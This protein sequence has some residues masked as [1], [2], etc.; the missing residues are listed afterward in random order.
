MKKSILIYIWVCVAAIS[1]SQDKVYLYNGQIYEG[2][3]IHN[4]DSLVMIRV[5]QQTNAPSDLIFY[6]DKVS[7]VK[8]ATDQIGDYV[9]IK[10]VNGRSVK[11][12]IVSETE[13]TI[14]LGEVKG[15]KFGIIEIPKR[16]I[17]Y[18]SSAVESEDINNIK[19]KSV[20]FDVGFLRGASL[21]GV[22]MEIVT[23]PGSTFFL[24]LGYKGFSTGLNGFFGPNHQGFGLKLAYWHQGFGD[25][26]AGSLLSCGLAY[27]MRPG[28]SLD[29]GLG[30]VL[31]QGNYNYGGHKLVL[32][33]GVGGRF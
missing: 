27:K 13:S 28:I 24:G 4:N 21:I 20:F 23:G 1:Y 26:F 15:S 33:Y 10:F 30:Y 7:R 3:V 25:S 32:T 17:L 6:K 29:L 11:G 16:Q 2:K 5:S 8:M 9:T 22:D 14:S 12:R 31:A 19:D 18:K